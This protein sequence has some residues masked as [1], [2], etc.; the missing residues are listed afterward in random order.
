MSPQLEASPIKKRIAH[1]WAVLTV[2]VLGQAMI[3]L[4]ATVVNIA[5]PS[6]QRDLGFDDGT[7]EAPRRTSAS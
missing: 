6:T 5:L 2:L 3:I 4:D 1:P 7:R